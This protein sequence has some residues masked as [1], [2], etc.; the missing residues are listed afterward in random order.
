MGDYSHCHVSATLISMLH[1]CV[2]AIVPC[3]NSPCTASPPAR[4]HSKSNRNPKLQN[5]HKNRNSNAKV[6]WFNYVTSADSQFVLNSITIS[7]YFSYIWH[8]I[9]HSNNLAAFCCFSYCEW[10]CRTC[11]YC[12]SIEFVVLI[13][14]IKCSL[15]AKLDLRFKAPS[16]AH[17]HT[18]AHIHPHT[19]TLA[20]SLARNTCLCGCRDSA[21]CGLV[22]CIWGL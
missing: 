5:K 15:T 10:C 16:H 11:S 22:A 12:C 18:H 8:F 2:I 4:R 9:R 21:V 19:H 1:F 17:G 7:I 6:V 14:R 3:L 20:H 13:K